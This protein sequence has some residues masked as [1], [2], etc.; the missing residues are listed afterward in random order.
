MDGAI[1]FGAIRALAALDA[2]LALI[3]RGRAFCRFLA[4]FGHE[5]ISLRLETLAA[6]AT[7]FKLRLS[8]TL[9]VVRTGLVVAFLL[10]TVW[11]GAERLSVD[12][13]PFAKYRL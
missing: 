8:R 3:A 1:A 4:G 11:A 10:V 6:L 5:R 9:R 12:A 7:K 13:A 2:A